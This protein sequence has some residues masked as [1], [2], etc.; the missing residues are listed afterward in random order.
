MTKKVSVRIDDSVYDMIMVTGKVSDIINEALRR[1]F[2][3]VEV[4]EKKF[5]KTPIYY[6]RLKM[7]RDIINT[8]WDEV[9]TDEGMVSK[10]YALT[11][12]WLT[13][14]DFDRKDLK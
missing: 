10:E 9:F 7:Y 8:D 3:W 4:E 6:K 1:Y 14:D 13:A 5:I 11:K 2:E 12:L